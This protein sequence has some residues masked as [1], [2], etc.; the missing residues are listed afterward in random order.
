MVIGQTVR[1]GSVG[2]LDSPVIS[3]R[4]CYDPFVPFQPDAEAFPRNNAKL[5]ARSTLRQKCTPE[6]SRLN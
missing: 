1:K 4:T 6:R 3:Q 5:E 2:H